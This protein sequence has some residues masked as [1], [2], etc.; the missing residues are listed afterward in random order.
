MS[1]RRR[2]LLLIVFETVLLGLS[3]VTARL[4]VGDSWR[5]VIEM[6]VFFLLMLVGCEA[7]RRRRKRK[8][9]AP[10]R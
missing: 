3:V 5:Q 8:A 9:S 2:L 7:A 6:C 1:Q 4:W 10:P